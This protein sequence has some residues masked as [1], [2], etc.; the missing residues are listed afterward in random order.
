MLIRVPVDEAAKIRVRLA[1]RNSRRSVVPRLPANESPS[2]DRQ[3]RQSQILEKG[4]AF[5][6]FR[7]LA[8]LPL[9]ESKSDFLEEAWELRRLR[10]RQ[11]ARL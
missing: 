8:T 3:G 2:V 6:H 1:A 11:S 5:L 4:A 10:V 9:D 7:Y